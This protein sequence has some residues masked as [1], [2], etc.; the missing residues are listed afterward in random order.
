MIF[1]QFYLPCLAHASYIVGDEQTG[2]AVVVDPQRDIDHYLAFAAENELI[3]KH[4]FLTHLHADFV[5]GHLELRDRVGAQ[6][7][8][9]AA[10]KAE[11]AFTPFRD[12]DVLELGH[13]RLK[14][15]ETPGHTRESISILI[16]DLNAGE[17]QPHAVLTGDTLFIG[18][19]GRPDLRA[20][21]GWTAAQL[22]SML[23]DSLHA[24]LLALP[25]QC[26]VYPAH[27]VGSLCGKA[28]SKE[29]FSTLGEQRRSNYALQPMSR[30]T[31][32]EV[33][34]ADQPDAPAY[35]NYN[36]VLNSKE[37]PTMDEALAQELNPLSLDR[38]LA[39]QSQGAKVLDTRDPAEFAAAHLAGSINIGL[40]GQYATWVGTVLDTENPIVIIATPGRE[41]EAAVRLGRIGFDHVAGYLKDGLHS[42]E[43]RPELTRDTERLSAQ[44]AAECLAWPIP[45]L[46]IDIRTPREHG[47]KFIADS[48][49]IPLNHLLE[50]LKQLPK[51]RPLLVYCAGGY[52]SSIAASLLQSNG[53]PLVSEIAGGIA[54]W[55]AAKLPV[56]TLQSAS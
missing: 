13:V 48:K 15:L 1:K 19:V 53:F 10:A 31:F 20:A 25:D 3:I 36:A 46:L 32:I 43:S 29:T 44:F 6:V 7:C 4:V 37:R 35:F 5:A 49:S 42:L 16:Y 47:Q 14:I 17:A 54:G 38:V 39:L 28:L 26:L 56:Q 52:R 50:N 45:P 55:E 33:V 22:G 9:G 21:L 24:K 8:L 11:Y 23:F 2:T 18:D 34:T 12:G 40:G 30:E 41:H 27:G 51:D